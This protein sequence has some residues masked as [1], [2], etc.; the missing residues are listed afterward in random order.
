MQAV[1]LINDL[2]G[3]PAVLTIDLRNLD[4]SVSPLVA[5]LLEWVKTDADND[6]RADWLQLSVSN[7]ERAYGDDEPDYGDADLLTTNP[8]YRP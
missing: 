2:N 5:G 6:E 8:T 7:L 1:S 3:D 4:P